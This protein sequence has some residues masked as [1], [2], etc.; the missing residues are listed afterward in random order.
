MTSASSPR[1]VDV[2]DDVVVDG[3]ALVV[4]TTTAGWV[5]VGLGFAALVVVIFGASVVLILPMHR[6]VVRSLPS[7]FTNNRYAT[8]F[9]KVSPQ[10][11]PWNGVRTYAGS[12]TE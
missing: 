1:V 10:A 3:S 2:D 12:D 9:S 4:V 6:F 7:F 5:V 11:E 8:S